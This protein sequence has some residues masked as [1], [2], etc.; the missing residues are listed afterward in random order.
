M[1]NKGRN[2]LEAGSDVARCL[3]DAV[4][5]LLPTYTGADEDRADSLLGDYPDSTHI[6]KALRLLVDVMLPGRMFP[7]SVAP[8]DLGVFLIRRISAAWRLLRP[9]VERALPFRW[10]GEAAR[11]EG[12][13]DPVDPYPESVRIMNEF[14]TR[15]H[16]TRMLLVEDIKAAYRGDPAALTFAEVQLA[17]PGLLAITSHR[18]AH[19]LYKL[20]VPIVPRVMSEWIHSKTGVDIHPGAQIGHGFFIDHATGV[21]IGETAVIG[22]N[23]KLYQGVTLGA[24]SFPLDENGN[25]IKHIRRHPTVGDDVIFYANCTILGDITIGSGTTIGGNVFLTEDVPPNSF[26]AAKHTELQIKTDKGK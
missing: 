13:P 10:K 5:T 12:A 16:E 21:V 9:E 26:V 17:Y 2:G 18:L 20:D 15:L 11:I 8:E 6:A 3:C 4:A 14:Y 25:P 23:V 22:N 7:G 24:K 1:G 19:E